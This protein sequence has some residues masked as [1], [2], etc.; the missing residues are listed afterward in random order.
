MFL[1]T[2]KRT[3]FIARQVDIQ[4]SSS[5]PNTWAKIKHLQGLASAVQELRS[6]L[7]QQ[8]TELQR[9]RNNDLAATIGLSGAVGVTTT[10]LVIYV[11]KQYLL[12]KLEDNKTLAIR[13]QGSLPVGFY[14]EG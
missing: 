11:F 14:T 3:L 7:E 5:D 1:F 8:E 9:N 2:L 12:K 4:A 10:A 6:K 13:K